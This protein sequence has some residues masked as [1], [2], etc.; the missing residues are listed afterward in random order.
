MAFQTRKPAGQIPNVSKSLVLLPFPVTKAPKTCWGV[1]ALSGKLAICCASA[2]R[3][4]AAGLQ[5]YFS[6]IFAVS[7]GLHNLKALF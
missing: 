3:P 4:H 6:V 5:S 1:D 2:V 7:I